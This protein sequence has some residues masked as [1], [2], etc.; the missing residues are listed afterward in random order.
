MFL[1]F[2]SQNEN[3]HLSNC[4]T[5]AARALDP[6]KGLLEMNVKDIEFFLEAST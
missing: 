3:S 1:V 6:C 5:L 4:R 2:N